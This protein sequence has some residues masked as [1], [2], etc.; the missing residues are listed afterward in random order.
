MYYRV[1]EYELLDNILV[2]SG[3]ARQRGADSG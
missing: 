1:S 3:W 2:G